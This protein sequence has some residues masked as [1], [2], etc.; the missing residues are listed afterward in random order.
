MRE[1]EWL[2]STRRAFLQTLVAPS[3]LAVLPHILFFV[4]LSYWNIAAVGFEL[5][6]REL[7]KGVV[8][9]AESVIEHGRDVVLSADRA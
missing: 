3:G 8:L 7:P 6:L 2:K 9:H 1:S 4:L 5:V